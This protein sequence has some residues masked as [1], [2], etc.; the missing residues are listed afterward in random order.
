MDV[1]VSSLFKPHAEAAILYRLLVRSSFGDRNREWRYKYHVLRRW[2]S[3]CQL[4]CSFFYCRYA[5]AL[6]VVLQSKALCFDSDPVL[7]C[8]ILCSRVCLTVVTP[9]VDICI[10]GIVVIIFIIII[11]IML[12]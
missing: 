2:C 10:Y 7:R 1:R 5:V 4:L 8:K 12:G 3:K 6:N 9:L 11:I